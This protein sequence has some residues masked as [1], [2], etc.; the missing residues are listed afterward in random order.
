[1]KK[2]VLF[3]MILLIWPLSVAAQPQKQI[4]TI[5][6]T[7]GL[8]TVLREGQNIPVLPYTKVFLKDVILTGSDGAVGILLKDN[9]LLSMGPISRLEMDKYNFE[10]A[11][12]EYELRLKMHQGSFVYLSGL[13]GKLA[14]NAVEL[15]TP[16][17]RI[18]MLKQANFMARF[19]KP[20]GRPTVAKPILQR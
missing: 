9:T 4:G 12:N 3:W 2:A 6:G 14:P 8:V 11:R 18:S 5:K 7:R 20:Q 10:P 13:L 19:A 1:M 15:D 16:V 17:G